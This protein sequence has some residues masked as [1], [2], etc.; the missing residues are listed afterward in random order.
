MLARVETR[1]GGRRG[2]YG[3]GRCQTRPLVLGSLRRSCRENYFHPGARTSGCDLSPLPGD[4]SVTLL[5][6]QTS[7]SPSHLTQRQSSSKLAASGWPIRRTS[8]HRAMSLCN[9][10]RRLPIRSHVHGVG[11]HMEL[12][13]EQPKAWIHA[14]WLVARHNLRRACG[15]QIALASCTSGGLGRDHAFA[16]SHSDCQR[17]PP[18]WPRAARVADVD[19]GRRCACVHRFGCAGSVGSCGHMCARN[20]S[21]QETLR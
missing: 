6:T 21:L 15:W 19:V 14:A 13:Y 11:D 3:E 4:K 7:A 2:G 9:V 12:L 10:D 17:H 20:E 5:G 8:R 18:L 16:P 1:L